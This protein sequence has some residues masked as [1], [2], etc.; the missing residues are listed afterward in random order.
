MATPPQLS[1][2][3]GVHLLIENSLI[4]FSVCYGWVLPLKYEGKERKEEK[5]KTAVLNLGYKFSSAEFKLDETIG[6]WKGDG[7]SLSAGSNVGIVTQKKSTVLHIT[8]RQ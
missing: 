6:G 7:S 2:P 1:G 8:V 5:E 4:W 3:G